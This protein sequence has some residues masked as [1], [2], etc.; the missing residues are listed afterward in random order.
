MARPM[1]WPLPNMEGQA[2]DTALPIEKAANSAIRTTLLDLVW[3]LGSETRR[4]EEV[5][6]NVID[7]LT[8]GGVE[9]SGN[10][11]GLPVSCFSLDG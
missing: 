3:R 9:L 6:D 10:F 11:R 8:S 1:Q 4:D 7:L 2:M 5:V